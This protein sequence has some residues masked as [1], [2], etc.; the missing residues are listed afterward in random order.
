MLDIIDYCLG[1]VNN[2]F[3]SDLKGRYVDLNLTKEWSESNTTE[4]TDLEDFRRIE[5]QLFLNGEKLL[6]SHQ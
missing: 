1:K 6:S 2:H 4:L 5:A 3:K